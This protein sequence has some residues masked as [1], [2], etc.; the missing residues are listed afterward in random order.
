MLRSIV[1]TYIMHICEM[2]D[3]M[4][5]IGSRGL[6][7]SLFQYLHLYHCFNVTFHLWKFHEVLGS[8]MRCEPK[9]MAQNLGSMAL[10]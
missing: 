5:F 9:N 4:F 1:M 2:F 7:K 8:C 10:N 3:E 6:I